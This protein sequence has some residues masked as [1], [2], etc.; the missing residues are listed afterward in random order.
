MAV[1]KTRAPRG[2]STPQ[3]STPQSSTPQS[4]TNV[5]AAAEVLLQREEERER[6]KQQRAER[7][8]RKRRRK[9]RIEERESEQRMHRSIE[10][11]KWCIVAICSV[12]VASFIISIFVLVRVHSRVVEIEGQVKRI[13]HIMDHPLENVGARLGGD[14]DTRF[15]ALIG[16]PE[17][18]TEQ[19]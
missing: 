5:Q 9:R 6:T 7:R 4:S 10:V 3:S 14:L 15:R 17:P 19:E 13:Q 2:N 1:K 12:W 11:I 18:G 16:L 8:R